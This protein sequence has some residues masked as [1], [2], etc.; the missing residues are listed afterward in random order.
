M[1]RYFFLFF[2]LFTY[3][4]VSKTAG[5]EIKSATEV[6]DSFGVSKSLSLPD[7]EVTA[8]RRTSSGTTSYV[9]DRTTLDHAQMLNMSDIM[10]LLPGGRTINSTLIN[11]TRLQLRSLTQERG[12]ASFGTG[13]EVDGIRLDN[14]AMS[15]EING[16]ST[17]NL[18]SSNIG[19]VEVISGIAG[20]EYGDISNGIVKVNSRRGQTQWI[21]EGSTNPYTRQVALHKG[22]QLGRKGGILNFSIEHAN[23]FSDIS[24][25]YTSYQRNNLSLG[26]FYTPSQLLAKGHFTLHTVFT[27]NVGG[28]N[29]K[30][31]PDAFRD[32]YKKVSDNTIRGMLDLKWLRNSSA[33]GV[34]NISLHTAFSLAEK[35]DENYSNYSSSS[36]QPL[37]H[38]LQNGYSS[39]LLYDDYKTLYGNGG[40]GILL[41][42]TGY[43]Y[44]RCFNDQKP[45]SFNVKFKAEWTKPL[46][47][48]DSR[49]PI[50]NKVMI[51]IDYSLSRNNGNGI[52]YDDIRYADNGWRPYVLR[53]L[54]SL[55]NMALFVEDKF[56][57]GKLHITAGLRDDITILKKSG[58]GTLSSLSPRINLSYKHLHAGFGKSVKL[59]GFQI[60]YPADSYTDRLASAVETTADGNPVYTY[61]TNVQ[62]TLP[63][64][65]LKWQSTNQVD[66]GFDYVFS[67]IHISLSAF[68]HKTINPYQRMNI[69]TPFSYTK[70]D[71]VNGSVEYHTYAVNYSYQNGTPVCRYGIEWIL[72][73]TICKA[74]SVR[75]AGLRL[76]LDGTYYHY[77]G[78]DNTMLC[79]TPNGTPDMPAGNAAVIGYYQGSN[80]T[81]ASSSTISVANGSKSRNLNL[82]ATITVQ[83]PKARLITT[84]KIESSLVN[85]K[86]MLRNGAEAD[87]Y[88]EL[89]PVYYSTWDN[90][91][92]RIPFAEAYADAKISNPQLYQQ[93]SRLIVK[94]NTAY[95]FNANSI[96]PYYSCNF[97][98]TKE[99]G[100]VFSLSVYANN[101]LN[102][103]HHVKSSQTHLSSS[104]YASAYIPKFYYG[105]S[106]RI[107]L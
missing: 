22:L 93:L 77:R 84:M 61:Y 106:L 34:F 67:P 91:Q 49:M 44:S 94:S 11:D 102:N 73:A 90:P 51:G 76:R 104:L 59:P 88:M 100:K 63:N 40:G 5:Q 3:S 38:T 85:Y 2:L 62:K 4:L 64:K 70:T 105:A 19:S 71:K 65:H 52:F 98:I 56:F 80:N 55:Q 45:V 20:V 15:D 16:A 46:T 58:Y 89:Y 107:K 53:T 95:Y 78:V 17:R 99:I 42:Q 97:S 1:Q 39:S 37:I 28:Y 60:L 27:G 24:S 81:S 9:M 26:Y 18:S 7:V 35:K 69:Y 41:G 68:W 101:F 75:V 54:P 36:M 43:W 57:I 79:G 31:D 32:T 66:V 10:S 92:N 23:S 21:V 103:M 96:S 82:N 29:S 48:D 8:Q 13:I 74:S 50:I 6:T 86:K 12:N 25:P 83:I 30:A 72:D 33:A 14:N 87:T 47:A